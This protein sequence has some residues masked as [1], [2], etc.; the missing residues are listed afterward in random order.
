MKKVIFALVCLFVALTGKAEQVYGLTKVEK[1]G[2]SFVAYAGDLALPINPYLYKR[3]KKDMASYAMVVFNG[4]K[5]TVMTLAHRANISHDILVVDSVGLDAEDQPEIY[6]RDVKNTPSVYKT[7]NDQWLLVQVGQKVERWFI[8]GET[9]V[10]QHFRTVP[11]E[12]ELTSDIPYSTIPGAVA[13]QKTAA[14]TDVALV[15]APAP[16]GE[17]KAEL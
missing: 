10:I 7:P 11:R 15:N 13:Q 9:K 2:T 6:L 17:K 3:V 16:Q 4:E 1:V 8:D 5:G 14:A 12:T